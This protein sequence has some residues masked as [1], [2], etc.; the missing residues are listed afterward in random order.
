MTPRPNHTNAPSRADTIVSSQSG[1]VKSQNKKLSLTSSVFCTMKIANSAMP[2]MDAIAPPPRPAR[3]A[4]S[5]FADHDGTPQ[6]RSLD[7]PGEA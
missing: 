1:Q 6:R 5:L 4:G 3:F 2:E 7:D